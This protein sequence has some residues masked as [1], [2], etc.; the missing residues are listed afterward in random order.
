VRDCYSAIIGTI[1]ANQHKDKVWADV[2][3]YIELVWIL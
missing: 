2:V 3:E 1:N